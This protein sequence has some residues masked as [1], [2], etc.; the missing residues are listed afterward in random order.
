[1]MV[2]LLYKPV[3]IL[4]GVF[5]AA[6]GRNLSKQLW[7]GATGERA[8]PRPTDRYRSWNQVIVA[9]M[10]RG[11]VFAVARAVVKR[12]GATGYERLTGWWPGR[13]RTS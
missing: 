5:A 12:G 7:Y 4:L 10:L 9:A 11:A 13:D 2:K 6:L 8:L 1:M 3:G